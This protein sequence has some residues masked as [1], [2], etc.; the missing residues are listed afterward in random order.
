MADIMHLLTPRSRTHAMAF[1]KA[2]TA[3]SLAGAGPMMLLTVPLG[4][5]LI[6][7][8]TSSNLLTAL[9]MMFLPLMVSAPVVLAS[10]VLVGIPTFLVLRRKGLE[11][12]AV[13]AV[14]GTVI[15]I[16][17]SV[18]TNVA[19]GG[20]A[21]GILMNLGALAGGVTGWSWWHWGRRHYV[22]APAAN[23]VVP[24]V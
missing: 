22:L 11:T 20:E 15:G 14:A 1:A 13:Y 24:R 23:D 19:M 12:K 2:V 3:G 9:R 21:G 6:L 10:S 8:D 17:I 4:M 5:V 18:I 16:A 7:Q